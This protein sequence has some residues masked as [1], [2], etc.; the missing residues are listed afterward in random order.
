M[1]LFAAVAGLIFFA[2]CD[3]DDEDPDPDPSYEVPTTYSFSNIQNETA[4][5]QLDML[6]ELTVYMKTANT[7]GTALDQQKLS[8]MYTNS[9]DPFSQTFS[10]NLQEITHPDEVATFNRFI[11]EITVASQSTTDGSDG[12]AGVVTSENGSS[13]YL[14]DGNGIEHIQL[15]EKGLMGAAFYYQGVTVLLGPDSEAASIDLA[16]A[17]QAAIDRVAAQWDQAFAYFGVPADFPNNADQARFHGKYCNGR[18]GLLNTNRIMSSFLVG[19]A[20]LI[21]GDQAS[22][23]EAR[24]NVINEWERVIAGTAIHYFNGGIQ[25]LSDD[26]IR[27]HE[28]SEAWA[29]TW[30]LKFNPSKRITDAQIDE[31][32]NLLGTNM[33]QVSSSNLQQA[34]DLLSTV[35]NMDDVKEQ[36]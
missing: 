33:Y 5:D 3:D 1:W 20:A 13:Q 25:N 23:N 26:A 11:S 2:G 21:N 10:G 34:R 7:P 12:T 22:F 14:F 30:S 15:I 36:L 31:V 32:L 18:D 19:R 17:D 29:F 24:N 27:N 9:N 8:D 35:Y 6:D 4:R 16:A 28:L